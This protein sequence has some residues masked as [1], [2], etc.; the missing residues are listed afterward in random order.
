MSFQRA[1]PANFGELKTYLE[2]IAKQ[3]NHVK[4]V[5]VNPNTGHLEIALDFAAHIAQ[6]PDV[7]LPL[8]R[9]KLDEAKKLVEHMMG[10]VDQGF[11]PS[12]A[13]AQELWDM[14]DLSQK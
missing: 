13:E 10:E 6:K 2:E 1:V 3:K 11:S 4:S 7:Y 9:A 12:D 5:I 14:L 8:K